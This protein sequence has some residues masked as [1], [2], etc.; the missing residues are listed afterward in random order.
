M[1]LE[2]CIILNTSLCSWLVAHEYYVVTIMQNTC[3][4]FRISYST[5]FKGVQTLEIFNLSTWA[6]E[7]RQ[8]SNHQLKKLTGL[9]INS[10]GFFQLLT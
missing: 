10:V 6:A 5:G 4:A 3:V 1:Q 7:Y 9:G 8:L 2:C